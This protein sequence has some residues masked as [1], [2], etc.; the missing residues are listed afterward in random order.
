VQKSFAA[1]LSMFCSSF[2]TNAMFSLRLKTRPRNKQPPEARLC[3][4]LTKPMQ[5]WVLPVAWRSA[6]KGPKI[7][8]RRA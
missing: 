1:S 2:K 7:S 6:Q 5:L 3:S 8:T 4:T